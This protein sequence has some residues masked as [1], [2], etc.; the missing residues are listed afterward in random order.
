MALSNVFAARRAS[1]SL[2]ARVPA[3]EFKLDVD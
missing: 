1:A 3:S 2:M